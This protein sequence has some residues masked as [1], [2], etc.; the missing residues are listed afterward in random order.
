M[1]RVLIADAQPVVRE[2]LRCMLGRE[3]D[4]AVVG[5]AADASTCLERVRTLRC[6]VL[7]LDMAL[8][9]GHCLDTVAR[10][11]R[12]PQAPA[13]LALAA[14]GQAEGVLR[15][16]RAGAAGCCG[17]SSQAAELAGAVRRVAGGVRHVPPELADRL[18]D[19]LDGDNPLHASLSDREY[20]V[21]AMLCEGLSVTEIAARLSLSVK[22][23]S[24]YR[25]RMMDK[26][27]MRSVADLVRYAVHSG[28]D[29]RV[30]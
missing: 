17:K 4:M 29:G 15:L 3:P 26:M 9:G 27:G 16:L 21:A 13:V 25:S 6:D 1:I 30:G 12:L 5:E 28:L 18:V 7:V 2:G 23:V 14:A 11:A 22:T 24:T 10:V 19:G 8:P 20:Q